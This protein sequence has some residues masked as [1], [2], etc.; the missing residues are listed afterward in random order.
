MN[1]EIKEETIVEEQKEIEQPI[2]EEQPKKSSKGTIIV[3]L[4]CLLAIGLVVGGLL[5]IN[6]TNEPLIIK[7]SQIRKECAYANDCNIAP[8]INKK[9]ETNI[10]TLPYVLNQLTYSIDGK[11]IIIEDDVKPLITYEGDKK[12]DLNTEL[13]LDNIKITDYG[14]KDIS[15]TSKSVDINTG[16]FDAT[17]EAIYTITV[18]ASDTTGNKTIENFKIE[19]LDRYFTLSEYKTLLNNGQYYKDSVLSQ[20][21]TLDNFSINDKNIIT[22]NVEDVTYQIDFTISTIRAGDF[23]YRLYPGTLKLG[24]IDY[25]GF[26]VDDETTI[27]TGQPVVDNIKTII[28]MHTSL[29]IEDYMG[30]QDPGSYI[31][32]R[33]TMEGKQAT[34]EE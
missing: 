30:A 21:P 24:A 16:G 29:D 18:T 26:R 32:D 25:N 4:I 28:K 6:K 3:I 33:T 7:M 9:Y 31:I 12:L 1:E 10:K 2:I 22:F 17:K 20:M 23:L 15:I 8:I 34:E 19:V 14:F 5:F 27:A 11:S 13:N